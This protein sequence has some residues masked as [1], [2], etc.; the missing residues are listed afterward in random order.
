MTAL[1]CAAAGD[2]RM[3]LNALRQGFGVFGRNKMGAGC[4]NVACDHSGC[5]IGKRTFVS[6]S[7]KTKPHGALCPCDVC[8]PAQQGSTA[9]ARTGNHGPKC[10]CEFCRY[11]NVVIPGQRNFSTSLN[12]MGHPEMCPCEFCRPKST[13]IPGRRNF[14]TALTKNNNHGPGCPC[15]TCAGSL[16]SSGSSV[17]RS[18]S[19]RSFST[20][21]SSSDDVDPTTARIKEMVTDN[22][23]CLFM[24]GNPIFPQ[25]GFSRLA[26]EVLKREGFEGKFYS[27]DVL[28]DHTIREGVKVFSD[29][30][31]VP[32]LY[33]K[34]EFIGGC[35][36]VKE[37][38]LSGELK[39]TLADVKKE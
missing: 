29:W 12:K 5:V 36:I 37:M 23:I 24:K 30:P 6:A 22:E 7:N 28:S 35:D 20:E 33:V 9:L 32:Q 19:Q 25:C 34:G 18:S 31:T 2:S 10:G 21:A 39:E 1:S 13:I 8:K 17:Q 14:S 16:A 26:C 27:F 4:G 38:H 15:N 3:A 11:K